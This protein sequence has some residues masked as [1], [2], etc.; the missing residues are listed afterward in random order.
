VT[1]TADSLRTAALAAA[2]RGWHVF[3]LHPDAKAPAI[4]S[5]E[6]RATTDPARIE[7]CWTAGPYNIGI[8][9]GPSRL[10]V[11]DL[12]VPKPGQT[13][14]PGCTESCG[15]DVLASVASQ[16]GQPVPPTFTVRTGRGGRHLY[17]AAPAGAPLR[18]T[19]GRLGPLIDTRAHG[20]YVVAPG[21]TVDGRPYAVV[22]DRP[23]APL[24]AWL[25]ALLTTAATATGTAP[26]PALAAVLTEAARRT[27]YL[28][29]ALR[30]EIHRVAAARPGTRNHTL[31]AAA[32][33]LGQLIA[34]DLLPRHT[35]E[36]ALTA[37]AL[38]AGLDATE[39][40]LTIC[41][42]LTAGARNPRKV[43]A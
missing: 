35:A 32:Y 4:R 7:R 28:G 14:A 16:A 42:G 10:V 1:D 8:A 33:N 36:E 17:Y 40:A 23:P 20:G 12:D 39:A 2:A 31:N 13:P 9:T 29:A 26:R 27:G 5:W 3:P 30:G 22:D 24:P 34:T 25:A 43:P 37:A 19:A 38:A 41:S 11:I 15:A 21:S 18:N 6:S